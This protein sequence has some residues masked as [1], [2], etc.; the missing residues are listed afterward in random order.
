MV[1][2]LTSLMDLVMSSCREITRDCEKVKDSSFPNQSVL[3]SDGAE[4]MQNQPN[5]VGGGSSVQGL[6][7]QPRNQGFQ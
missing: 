5:S 3:C 7:Y 1:P 6:H 2:R 4:V